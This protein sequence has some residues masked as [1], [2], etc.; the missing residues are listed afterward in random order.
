[1]KKK[2]LSAILALSMV[3]TMAPIGLAYATESGTQAEAD[4]AGPGTG[5]KQAETEVSV[6]N[7]PAPDSGTCGENLTWTLDSEGTLTISGSGEMNDYY[8]YTAADLCCSPWKE[9]RLSIQKVVIE[10]GVTN[11]GW[12]A[13]AGCSSLISINIPDSVDIIDSFAFMGCSS[14][15]SINIPD[16]VTVIGVEAF[17]GCSSLID[18]TLPK[19]ITIYA[20]VFMDTEYYNTESNWEDGCLYYNEYLLDVRDDI[21]LCRVKEG[22]RVVTVGS[23]VNKRGLTK[24]IIPEGVEDLSCDFYGC[25]SL[26]E[27]ILPSSL[28][29][30]DCLFDGSKFFE[31]ESNW[32][33]GLLYCGNWLVYANED[34]TGT[35]QVKEGTI[36]IATRTFENKGITKVTLPESVIYIGDFAFIGCKNLTEI[37]IPKHVTAVGEQVFLNCIELKSLDVPNSVEVIGD[38]AFG[39]RTD[40]IIGGI[41]IEGFSLSG[42]FGS[43]AEAYAKENGIPFTGH[44]AKEEGASENKPS[45][46]AGGPSGETGTPPEGTGGPSENNPAEGTETP[47]GNKP[48]EETGQPA[49]INKELQDKIANTAKDA[50]VTAEI[51]A[52]AIVSKDVIKAA[53]EKGVKLEIKS[54]SGTP[55]VWTLT[56][57]ANEMDFNPA[58]TAGVSIKPI[59]EKLAGAALSNTFQYTQIQFAHEGDLPGK[60]VATLDLSSIGKFTEGETVYL[61]YY[62]PG[63]ALF[64]KVGSAVYTN[65]TAAFTMTHCSDYIVANQELPAALTSADTSQAAASPGTGDVNAVIYYMLLLFGMAAIVTV[66][67]KKKE[68]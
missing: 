7:A 36:G 58:V 66:R 1:M 56:E 61:Y 8:D 40:P 5:S 53:K 57:I 68:C 27:I 64:E 4:S 26:T 59:E 55:S 67:I 9:K 44:E 35:V 42:S 48:A 32:E 31:T 14:L 12:S 45:E 16:S 23:F 10:T 30:V 46:G 52:N 50:A 18:I 63:T 49:D 62:N 51:P 19:G 60:A 29:E 54:T 24:I 22:T 47:S 28:K 25:S 41:L 6:Q 43:A 2:L 11:I 39:F 33:N 65:G 15:T 17:A 13:F 37:N 20:R 21:S 3:F 38:Y 34:L